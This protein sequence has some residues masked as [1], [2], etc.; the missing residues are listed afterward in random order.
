MKY[1][2]ILRGINVGGHRKILMKDLKE[3]LSNLGLTEI[4]TYIQSGNVVFQSKESLTV[5]ET[6]IAQ[7]IKKNYNFEVPVII[8]PVADLQKIPQLNPYLNTTAVEKLH[9]TFLSSLPETEKIEKIASTDFLPDKFRIIA[10][11]VFLCIDGKYHKSKLSN[12]FFEKELKVTAT[13]RNWKTI[14]KLIEL[15]KNN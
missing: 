1:L 11:T 2:A 9:V 12:N 14:M 10:Q 13:T 6:T 3:L 5:L 8:I 7:I 15:S 4:K